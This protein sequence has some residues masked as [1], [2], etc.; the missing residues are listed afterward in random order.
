ME[1][2]LL[3]EG[4]REAVKEWKDVAE[5]GRV[6]ALAGYSGGVFAFLRSAR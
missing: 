2:L 5:K 1:N 3:D 4:L 6:S